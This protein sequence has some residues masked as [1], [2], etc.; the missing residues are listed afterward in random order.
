[1]ICCG[2]GGSGW[3]WTEWMQAYNQTP[4]IRTRWWPPDDFFRWYANHLVVRIGARKCLYRP[5]HI[6]LFHYPGSCL[7]GL[8]ELWGSEIRGKRYVLCTFLQLLSVSVTCIK[9][10]DIAHEKW[11]NT[12]VTAQIFQL[13][14]RNACCIGVTR[15][16]SHTF[17][18]YNATFLKS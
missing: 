13:F 8:F 2:W 6:S 14:G 17:P 10:L 12:L 5:E 9:H 16:H 11:V 7:R 18:E 1:M 3:Y 4:Q 15:H